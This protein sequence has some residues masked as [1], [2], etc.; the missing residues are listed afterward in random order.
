VAARFGRIDALVN[1]AG[2][3]GENSLDA[4]A[5]DDFWHQVIGVNL[6]GTYFMSKAVLPHLGAGGRIV[7]IASVL[8]L[9]GV[10]DQTAYCA[11]KHGV[12]GFTRALSHAVAAR[13]ITVNAICP[14]WTRTA[15]AEA[16]E[17]WDESRNRTLV[18]R[19]EIERFSLYREEIDADSYAYREMLIPFGFDKRTDLPHPISS[20]KQWFSDDLASVASSAGTTREELVEGLCSE[21][22]MARLWA[23]ECIAGHHGYENFDGYPLDLSVEEMARREECQPPKHPDYK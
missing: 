3:A 7:N 1:N 22:I 14:G 19:F 13:G 11:A 6:N 5:T 8:G 12:V 17:M 20:Y 21:D 23:L 9:K 2:L 18:F 15:K 4:A 16:D 10:P